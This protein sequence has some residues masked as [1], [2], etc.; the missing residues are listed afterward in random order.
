M[1]NPLFSG[2]WSR[3]EEADLIQLVN[4]HGPK[5]GLFSKEFFHRH[6]D[7]ICKKWRELQTIVDRSAGQ[8]PTVRQKIEFGLKDDIQLLTT[9][10]YDGYIV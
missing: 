7:N 1:W 4:Q 10:R 3:D 5:W 6:A 2:A 8:L 9:I